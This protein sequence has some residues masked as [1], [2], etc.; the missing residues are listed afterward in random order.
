MKYISGRV[1]RDNHGMG[2][3]LCPPTHPMHTHRIE[4]DLRRKPENRGGMSL[5]YA[6]DCEYLDPTIRKEAK[7]ILNNWTPPP[8][9]SPEIQAWIHQVLGYFK[10]CYC[11]GNG[12]NP[13]D[14]YAGNLTIGREGTPDKH[15]GVHLIRK[16]YPN[17]MPT[18][19]NWDMAYWGKKPEREGS[20]M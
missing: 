13:E 4:T 11:R 3:F 20:T 10:G 8:V 5:D 19:E 1:V 16:Y 14:W 15:V 9:E 17:F 12:S 7:K 18:Q 2:G 6:V